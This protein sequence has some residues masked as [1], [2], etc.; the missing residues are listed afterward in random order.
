MNKMFSTTGRFVKLFLKKAAACGPHRARVKLLHGLCLVLFFSTV[1]LA[2]DNDLVLNH[3]DSPDPVIAGAVVVY[4]VTVTNGGDTVTI[5]DIQLTNTLPS[6]IAFI[7][8]TPSQGSCN[9]TPTPDAGDTFTCALGSLM[10]SSS[11]TVTVQ[12]RS[13]AAGTIYNNASVTSITPG[14][15]DPDITNNSQEEETTVNRGANLSL[16]KSSTPSPSV[17]SG[18]TLAYNLTVANAGPDTASSVRVVDTLPPGFNVT[19]AL[20]SGCSQVGQTITCDLSGTIDSADSRVVGPING[21][22]SVSSGTLTNAASVSITSPAA[23]QDPDSTNNT[24]TLVTTV[25]AGSDVTITKS[26]S[27]GNPVT[28]GTLFNYVLTPRYTGDIPANIVVTDAVPA[29]ITVLSVSGTGWDCSATVLQNVSCSRI[30]GGAAA[31][32]NVAM[33]AITIAVQA[34]TA[35]NYT[36]TASVTSTTSDPVPGNNSASQNTTIVPAAADLHANKSAL[37]TNNS[38]LSPALVVVGDSFKWRLSITNGGPSA[39]TG[40]LQLTDSLPANVTVNSYT[41]QTAGYWTCSPAAPVI[42]DATITC[43]TA[44]G[45]VLNNGATTPYLELNVTATGA[46]TLNNTAISTDSSGTPEDNNPAND[47]ATSTVISQINA[48]AADLRLVKTVSGTVTAGDLLSYTLQIVNLTAGVTSTNVTLRDTLT[49]LIN[50]QSGTNNGLESAAITTAGTSAGGSCSSTTS[51]STGRALTCTFTSIAPC[52]ENT[53][54]PIVTIQVRPNGN[55]PRTNSGT[56]FSA[57]V[58][59]PDISNNTSNTVSSTVDQRT[60]MIVSITDTPDPVQVG[61]NLTYVATAINQGVSA[62]ENATVTVT[63][64]EG[65]AFL[66]A[67]PTA[68]SCTTT[69]G[70]SGTITTGGNKTVT[71]NLGTLSLPSPGN[72]TTRAVTIVVRPTMAAGSGAFPRSIQADAAVSTSTAETDTGNNASL[73]TTAVTAPSHDML[74]NKTDS[75]DPV[76]VNDNITYTITATNSGPSYAS[77]VQIVDTLPASRLIFVSATAPSGGSCSGGTVGASGGILTCSLGDLAAGGSKQVTVVMTGSAKGITNNTVTVSS[78]ETRDTASYDPIQSN[79]TVSEDT[80][81]RTKADPEVVSKTTRDSADTTDITEI[82]LRRPFL[83]KIAVRNNAGAGLAEA[84]NVSLTDTLPANMELTATPTV[85]VTS[86]SFSSTTCTGTAGATSFSCSLGTV[87]SGAEGTITVPV[88]VTAVTIPSTGSNSFSNTA[89]IAT[90]SLDVNASNN[91]SSGTISVVSSSLAGRVWNDTDNS[92]TI[93]GA[94]AGI[95]GVTIT[96]SGTSWD[97]LAVNRTTTTSTLSSVTGSYKFSGLPEGIYTITE[98]TPANAPTGYVDGKDILGTIDG[99]PAGTLNNDQAASI[100]LGEHKDGINYSFGELPQATLAG[101]VFEDLNGDGL[102]NGSDAGINAVTI[103]ISGTDDLGG[104]VNRNATTNASGNYSLNR[105]RP[106]TY[107]VTQTQPA[108]YQPGRTSVGTVTGTGAQAGNLAAGGPTVNVIQN[109]VLVIGSAA[110]SYNFAEVRYAT[111]NGYSYVDTD[112]NGLKGGSETV[113]IPGAAITLTGTDFLGASVGPANTTTAANGSYSFTSLLP[114]TYTVTETKPAGMTHTGAQVGT[115]SGTPAGTAGSDANTQYVQTIAVPSNGALQNYNF[116]HQGTILGGYV[117]VDLNNDGI[118][119]P[120]EPGISGV[121]VTLSGNA[122]AGGSVCDYL[123]QCYFDT[124]SSGAFS[125]I[126]IPASD[127]TGYTLTEQS[128]S[129]PPLS[130]YSDGTDSRGTVAGIPVGNAGNDV[131]TGIVIATS[132]VGADYRFGEQGGSITGRV[133]YDANDDGIYN[134]S[135]AGIAGV[136]IVLSG[137]AANGVNVCSIMPTCTFTTAA[138]GSY[139]LTGLPASNGTGYTLTQIQPVDYASRTTTAGTAGGS[140]TGTTISGIVLGAG[141]VATGYLFGEK[142]GSITGFVYHDANND[143]VKDAGEPGISGVTL[144][145]A[146]TIASGTDVCST[147]PGCTVTTAADGSYSFNGLLNANGSGYT[148][149]ET[150][151]SDYLDGRETAGTQGGTVDNSAFDATAARNRISAI[152]FSAATP[153]TGYN[154]GEVLSGSLAGRV[155]HDFNNNSIYEAGEELASVTV[156]LTGN[157]DQGTAINQSTTTAADGSYSFSNL[158]P[159]GAGG[160]TLTE[161]QPAG[162]GDFPGATG[163]QIGNLGGTASIANVISAIGLASGQSGINYNFRDNASS[164]SGFVYL[165]ENNNGI[166]DPGEAGIP[167]ITV[168][169]SGTANRTLVTAADG[170]YQFIGLTSGTYALEETH[171]IIYLDGLETAGLAGGTVDNSSFS[172]NPAQNRISAIALGE[173]INGSGYLFGNRIGLPGSFSGRVWYNSITRDQT[174]EP[175]EPGMANWQVEAVQG[176]IVRGT[177][178]TAADGTWTISGLAAGSGYELRFRHPV[179][180]VIYGIPVSQ[181]TGYADS[182]PDYSAMTIANMVLRSGGNVINQNLPIDPSGVVYDAITRLPVAGAVVTITGP[183]GFNAAIHLAGGAANV[184]QV[185]DATGF[186]QFLLLSGS[187][188]G[189]YTIS[190]LPPAG[191]VPGPSSIIPPTAG[192]FTVPGGPTIAIQPQPS[193]PTGAQATTYYLAFAMSETSA[194]VVNNHIPVDPVLGGAII[195]TK[196][197]PLVNVKRGD[198]VPYTITMTNTLAATLSNID[199]RDLMPPGFKYRTGSGTLN[200]IRTEPLISGRELTWRNLTFAPGE[201]K[202]FLLILVVGS[203]VSE[204]EYTNQV[205]AL[206]NIVRTAVSNIATA[207]VRV[208]PDPTFDCADIIGKVFDDK[209]ANGYPDEGEPGLANI[210]LATVRGLIITTDAEGRFHIPCPEIPNENRGSNYVLKLDERTLPSGYRI[211]TENPRVVRLTRGKMT[212]MNFGATVHRVVRVDVNDAAF[213]KDGTKLL[214]VWQQKIREL[215]T[216]LR[217]RPTVVRIAYR[218]GKESKQLV[219]SRIRTIRDMLQSLWKKG[220]DCPPLVFEEEIVEIR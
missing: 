3:T 28:T 90:S 175:G 124:D 13:S 69:P 169:L 123:A 197:T 187:P 7:S 84:D 154:F 162:I 77:D 107:T 36:N 215:E 71:C 160:Y 4:T 161:T 67:S 47:G 22:I 1:A 89:T 6:G 29:G 144:T 66:S 182:I 207:T 72:T 38:A 209:N 220:K 103:N 174:Q 57:D 181:D 62:A 63:L 217:E 54:C 128:Q 42:G 102:F 88:R 179:N 12:V 58:A 24:A 150:Q 64:P 136:T 203:G 86:G 55:T 20:P 152:P 200:S 56:V 16:A 146:G 8:A 79:N 149:T 155:Y 76:A 19:G 177:A 60:D 91:S 109:L 2:A 219:E 140:V 141:N 201:K 167:G 37:R 142:T 185:T 110:T 138:D 75:P 113:G 199:V 18:A 25:T 27:V 35:A 94:E 165:D 9:L 85:A 17:Q 80:T 100:A 21:Q 137:T 50:N 74:V 121:R 202:T 178:S 205:F 23:P 173:G 192:P 151:A 176:G 153:A 96:L 119:D 204:G 15:I 212:K 134:G 156:T 216:Q 5:N 213:E 189:T 10:V 157:D 11:A 117:Y 190:T 131:I 196:T 186:Y 127:A 164:L 133:Y 70:V 53:D 147:I 118:R 171:P 116:G 41:N 111:I 97:S 211:T 194:S 39:F 65:V 101:R 188:S 31:G 125:F 104:A 114:G 108:A 46:G 168:T 132:Q 105:L 112:G 59:D 148:I 166:K 93:N 83:W 208:V 34:D 195:A 159:A 40:T 78:A 184:S 120:G 106:G 82:G 180:N 45:T 61:A 30:S 214:D 43:T 87:S 73:T 122:Q 115:G 210:R 26:Q 49:N 48:D 129:S 193:P 14:F 68:G 126:N 135:D 130:N 99:S 191:Y 143:G 218:T 92:G 158:R 172:P 206:N 51:G 139:S 32:Y 145:L 81:V 95:N 52:I 98:Y 33:P 198:L 170:S 44:P 163:S 183:P